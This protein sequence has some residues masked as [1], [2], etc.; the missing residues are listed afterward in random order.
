[1]SKANSDLVRRWLHECTTDKDC[2][3]FRN[4]EN[5][6]PKRLLDLGLAGDARPPVLID[7]TET[8]PIPTVGEN[9][10]RYACL[11]YCWGSRSIPLRTTSQTLEKH[12][13]GIPVDKIPQVFRDAVFVA[14]QLGL[15]YLWIDALCIIQDNAADWEKESG[16]MADIFHHSFIT[17]G[18]ATSSACDETFLPQREDN[19][20][21]MDFQSSLN[22]NVSGHHSIFPLAGYDKWP[23][24]ADLRASTWNTRGWVWQ[25]QNIAQRILVFGPK[26]LHLRCHRRVLSENGRCW[27]DESNASSLKTSDLREW[28]HWIE[29]YSGRKFT[30]ASDKLVAASGLAK[31][32]QKLMAKERQ[33]PTYL[34]GLWL[35]KDF[36]HNFKWVLCRKHLSFR[37][38]ID[39]LENNENYCAPSWSWA[40]RSSA[41]SFRSDYNINRADI[42]FELTGQN[43]IPAKSDAMVK[44]SPGSS[45]TVRGK[46]LRLFSSPPSPHSFKWKDMWSLSSSGDFPR[47]CSLD[48]EPCVGY[49]GYPEYLL[50]L[51]VTSVFYYDLSPCIEYAGLILYPIDPEPHTQF[52][53]VGSFDSMTYTGR[54]AWS[55]REVMIF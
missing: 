27:T 1:M 50:H 28:V 9:T 11:S 29:D 15:R 36:H 24:K 13:Q 55:I 3:Q 31:V 26:M 7:T 20:I 30:Y 6:V 17:F 42:D 51:F 18:A 43:L 16:R 12:K 39:S 37:E 41:V 2:N 4:S 10:L 32:M 33:A 34:A 38:M 40:S 5:F 23:F 54:R 19:L 44:I 52:L 22:P 21:H 45:I 49:D 53:R 25:E 8:S 48:W 47:I 35:D 46:V 14:R